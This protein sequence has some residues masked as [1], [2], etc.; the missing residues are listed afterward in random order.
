[1][2]RREFILGVGS[3]AAWPIAADA[4]QSKMPLIGVLAPFALNDYWRP[5][6]AS[7]HRGLAETGY[8]EGRNLAVEYRWAEDHY[9]RLPNLAADLVRRQVHL[10]LSLNNTPTATAAK[11]ATSSIPIVFTVGVDPVE[12]GLVSSLARPGGNLT[13][14][15]TLTK[16]V[17]AKKMELLRE[18]VPRAASV[19]YLYNPTNFGSEIED[20]K[21]AA[22]LLGLRLMMMD[23]RDK[24]EIGSAFE[25]MARDRPD[26]LTVSSDTIFSSYSDLVAALAKRNAIPSMFA[27][28]EPVELGG[29]M[30]YG[31]NQPEMYHQAGI[32][33]GRILSGE[34]PADLPVQRP[35]RLEM[36]INLRTA[37]AIG[38]AFP[39]TLLAQ[40]D[41]VI[42]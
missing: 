9:D 16:E 27:S 8:V 20:V 22:L 37:K 42:E 11:A 23:A 34:K 12:F 4:Q 6:V 7:V 18:L 15:T 32:Y 14:F 38:I 35:T 1:M 41:E 2:R 17:M 24:N 28:R 21:K 10:I 25:R 40:A 19:A 5:R 36:V 3:A 39:Q 31:I 13:G 33:A 29:L 30:S 26:V